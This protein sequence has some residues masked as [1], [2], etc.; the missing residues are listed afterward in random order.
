[1]LGGWALALAA[2][3]AAAQAQAPLG[4]GVEGG[5]ELL[6]SDRIEAAFGS[7]GIEVLASDDRLRVS[8]LY[9]TDDGERTTRTYAVVVYPAVV[10]AAFADAHAAILA[11]GSIGATLRAY[12]WQVVKKH[13]FFGVIES[14]PRVERMMRLDGVRNLA[15]HVYELEIVRGSTQFSYA[16]I[17]EV[18]HPDY[19][20]ATGL[21]ALYAPGWKGASDEEAADA[22]AD[23]VA[24]VADSMR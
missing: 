14:T 5:P 17:A 10:D 2:L 22:I 3:A 8:D 23:L 19:L 18:H 1:M 12:G 6:N 24:I 9:S 15:L 7:Y 20:G 4:E 16:T 13:R 11:G 21:V